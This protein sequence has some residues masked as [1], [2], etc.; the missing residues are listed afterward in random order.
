MPLPYPRAHTILPLGT[1]ISYLNRTR[2]NNIVQ[3]FKDW[4]GYRVED[5]A[6]TR[7]KYVDNREKPSSWGFK[8]ENDHLGEVQEWFKTDFGEGERASSRQVEVRRLYRDFLECL[9]EQLRSEF[10]PAVLNG[11]HWDRA[12]IHFNFSVPA[13]WDTAIVDEFCVLAKR[14]G[15][16]S[17]PGFVV[18]PSLTEPHA[19]AAYTLSSEGFIR[20]SAS[21]YRI[22]FASLSF[23]GFA[24]RVRYFSER[25]NHVDH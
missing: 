4:G 2:G 5:K 25:R 15:F 21:S 13:T 18:K 23:S 11:K 8:C 3:I 22:S 12:S 20:V 1:G 10:P 14:A 24:D 19:V 9:Y 6:P 17:Q 7:L 16:G